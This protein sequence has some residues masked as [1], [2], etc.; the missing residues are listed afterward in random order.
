MCLCQFFQNVGPCLCAKDRKNLRFLSNSYDW[1]TDQ[2]KIL[3]TIRHQLA[4]NI[5]AFKIQILTQLCTK[6]AD[7]KIQ[8]HFTFPLKHSQV[9]FIKERLHHDEDQ[10]R[11]FDVIRFNFSSIQLHS[12]KDQKILQKWIWRFFPFF[13]ALEIF[14][15][16]AFHVSLQCN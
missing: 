4:P 14:L 15:I 11:K 13:L 10:E 1:Q 2:Q 6:Y 5:F 12:R 16:A 3:I 8:E 9:A 7:L